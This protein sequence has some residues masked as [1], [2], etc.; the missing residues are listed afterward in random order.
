MIQIYFNLVD[1]DR[2][3]REALTPPSEIQPSGADFDRDVRVPK[4]VEKDHCKKYT[5][6]K[7]YIDI[8]E[9][10]ADDGNQEVVFDKKYDTFKIR[11]C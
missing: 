11:Y 3:I 8:D 4:V 6:A 5:L 1:V 2:I 7:H 9:L 10:R